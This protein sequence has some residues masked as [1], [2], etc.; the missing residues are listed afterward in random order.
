MVPASGALTEATTSVQVDFTLPVKEESLTATSFEVKALRAGTTL[1]VPGTRK[2]E[3]AVRGSSVVFN[4]EAPFQDGDVVSVGVSGLVSM[5]LKPQAVPFHGTFTVVGAQALQP[6]IDSLKPASG[7][8]DRTTVVELT[9]AGFRAGDVVRVGGRPVTVTVVDEN[10]LSLTIPP[11]PLDSSGLPVAGAAAVEVVDPS[12][13]SALKLGGFVFRDT[14]KLLALSPDRAPQQGGVK[15]QLSGRGFAPGMKVSFGGTNSF[16]VR[17]LGTQ[18]AE[19]VAPTHVAGVVDVGVTLEGDTSLLPA[20]FLYGSGAVSRLSTPPVRDVLVDNGVAYA[21]LG[22]T[23][24]VYGANGTL[25]AANRKTPNGGLLLA[26]LSEPTHVTPIAQL[27]FPGEGGSRRVLKQGNTVY[28]AAGSSGVQRVNVATPG[29]PALYSALTVPG[30]AVDIA[31]GGSLLFVGDSEGVKVFDVSN[32][33][34][35]AQPLRV[36]ARAIPGGVGALALH[37]SRLLVSSAAKV[38]PKFY[39]LDARTGDLVE[40]GVAE[41]VAPAVHISAEGTRAFLALGS[42][43]QVAIYELSGAQPSPAGTLV[44][45]DPLGGTW[46]SAEQ[47]RVAA[48]VAYVAAGGGKVQRFSVREGTAP[49]RLGQ[50]AVVGDARTLAFMGRYLLVGT[51]VLDDAGTAVELPLTDPAQ[52][53]LQ[54]AGALASVE[55]DTLEIRGTEPA[56]GDIVAPGAEVHVLLTSLP[57]VASAG[58]VTLVRA[59]DGEPVSV[60]RS[61]VTDTQGG[62]VVL[63]PAAPLALDTRYELRV[64]AGLKD[65]R[66]AM[67]G[68]EARVRFRTSLNASQERPE[69]ASVSPAYGLEAGGNEVDVLGTGFLQDCTVKV[70]GAVAA[71]SQV[72]Q[73]GK[74]VHVT[75]PPGKAGAAAVEVINP[76]GLSHVRLGAYR[77]LSLPS[78]AAVQPARAPYSSR[79]VVTLTGQGLFPG[80]QVSFGSVPARSVTFSDSGALLVEVPDDVTGRVDLTVLTPGTPPQQATL[81]GGFTFTL[82]KRAQLDG[83]GQVVARKD[84][85]LF[86]ARDGFLTA[87]DFSVPGSPTEVGTVTGVTQPVD[88]ALHG[89]SLFLAGKG[90]VVR[91][92]VSSGACAPQPLATCGPLEKDRVQLAPT[93]GVTLRAVAAGDAGAYVAVAGGNELALL[94]PVNGVYAVVARTLLDSGTVLDLDLVRGALVVLVRDGAAGARLEVR[95]TEIASLTRLRE[96]SLPGTTSGGDGALTHEGA[97]LA[98]SV[99]GQLYLFDLTEVEAPGFVASALDPSGGTSST[100]SLSGPWLMAAQGGRVSWLDTTQGLQERTFADGLGLVSD[101]AVINGVAVAASSNNSLHVFRVPYPAVDGMSPLPGERV[102]QGAAVSVALASEVPST[103]TQASSLALWDGAL[104]VEGSLLASG[105]ALVFTPVAALDPARSYVARLGLG[106]LPDVVGGTVLGPWDYPLRAG[107]PAVSLSIS[108]VTPNT[109]PTAG[110]VTVSVLGAGFDEGTQVFI[111]GIAAPLVAPFEENELQVSL[112]QAIVAGPADVRVRRAVDGVEAVAASRFLYVAPLSFASVTPRAVDLA[113]GTVSITGA[114]FHRGLEVHFDGVKAFT[115]NLTASRVDAL[116]PAGDERH[117]TLTLSQ[118]G[119]T[120]VVVAQAVYRGDVRAPVV[121]RVEPMATVGNQNVP[122]A[123]VFDVRFDET[124]ASASTQGLKLLR[125]PSG[126]AVPGTAS[127]LGDGRTLRFTPGAALTSTTSYALSVTGVTDVAGNI[128]PAF[129]RVFRTVDTVKPTLQLRRAGGAVVVEQARFAAEVAWTFQVVATDDSGGTTTTTL[130]VDG[131][132]VTAT[133]GIYRYTW[134]S[135]AM[136]PSVLTATATDASGNV[137]DPVTVTVTVVEDSPPDVSFQQPVADGTRTEGETQDILV[138]ASDNHGLVSVELHLDGVPFARLDGLSGTSATLTRTLRLDPVPGTDLQVQRVLTAYATDSEGQV[139]AAEQRVVTVTRDAQAPTVALRSPVEGGRVVGGSEL[140]L[141][142]LASDANGVASVAFFV[143]GTQV[144]EAQKAPWT[145]AWKAPAV[146]SNAS[147]TVKAVAKDVRGNA[148]EATAL[149]TVEPSSARPYVAWSSPAAGASLQEGRPF[150]VS[151]DASASAG[152]ASVRVRAG[153]EERILTQ[154]PW[155]TTFVA[156]VLEAGSAPLALEAQVTDNAGGTSTVIRRQV[157]VVDD[158]Q[159]AVG[160]SLAQEPDGTLLLGG[161]TL[162]LT[163]ATD[164]G[165]APVLTAK[166]GSVDLPVRM[167][168]GGVQGEAQLPEGPEGA[169][170]LAQASVTAAGGA[171]AS[172][173]HAGT[174]A[175]LSSGQ[176]ARVEDAADSLTPVALV[177]RGD[178]VLVVRSDD[179]G[180]GVVELRSRQTGVKLATRD[181]LG[182]PVGAAFVDDA[183]VV[184]LSRNGAGSLERFSLSTLEPQDSTTLARAPLAMDGAGSWLALGT[185]E[186]VEVRRANGSLAGRLRL[187]SVKGVSAEGDRLF[188]LTGTQLVAVDVKKPHAPKELSRTSLGTSGFTAV[189]A[190]ADGGVCSA[191]AGVKCFGMDGTNA[192]VARGEA[193]M[194]AP[195]VSAGAFGELLVVGTASGAR[196]VDVRGAPAVAGVYP[197]MTGP[198]V[199]VPGALVGGLPRGMARLPVVRG[200]ATPQLTWTLV[201]SA[202]QGSRLTLGAQTT[203]D[204]LPLNG[205][206]AEL[207]VNGVVVDARDSSLPQWV[208]LPTTGSNA[209]V[210]LLVRDLAGRQARVTREVS[211]TEPTGGPVLA[212]AE[213]PPF[214]EEGTTFAVNAVPV[215]PAQV[216]NVEVTLASGTPVLLPA[217]AFTGGLLAPAVTGETQMQ[218]SFVAIDAQGRRGPALVLPVTVRDAT[219]AAPSVALERRDGTGDSAIE[220]QFVT[221]RATTTLGSASTVVSFRLD[222]VEVAWG[223]GLIVDATVRMPLVVGA[224]QV[225]LSAVAWE[226]GRESALATLNIQVL[227]DLT[228]PTLSIETDPP[229][230]VVAAGTEL[231]ATAKASDTLALA[232]VSLELW[233][234]GV[235]QARSGTVLSFHVPEQTPPGTVL[236]LRGRAED[237]SGNVETV[238]VQRTVV[239]PAQPAD[240]ATVA[241]SGA[242]SVTRLGERVYAAHASGLWI[243]KVAGTA[244]APGLET[245]GSLATPVA[246]KALAVWGKHAALALGASGLWLV[247]VSVPA[248]PVVKAR[249]AGNYV[250]VAAADGF[251]AGRIDSIYPASERLDVGDPS[252]PVRTAIL[253]NSNLSLAGAGMD[254]PLA[255]YGTSDLIVYEAESG[256]SSVSFWP[257]VGRVARADGDRLVVGTD[258]SLVVWTRETNNVLTKVATLELPSG[259]R[260]MDVVRGVAYVAGDDG[261][262]RVVDLREPTSPRIVSRTALDASGLSIS[263]GL[264]FAAGPEGVRAMRLPVPTAGESAGAVVLADTALGLTPFRGGALVAARTAGVHAVSVAGGVAPTDLGVLRSGTD[265][266][267]VERAGRDV[268]VLDGQ[269]LNVYPE[270]ANGT[271]AG[272][273]A[274]G[275]AL[276]ASLGNVDRFAASA[277]RIWSVSAGTVKS[278][279]WPSADGFGSLLLGSAV[280]DVAGDEQHA[281]VALGAQGVAV[282]EVA[283]SGQLRRVATLPVNA[284]TVAL[285]GPLAIAGGASSFSVFTLANG[286]APQ[287]VGTVPT[288]G[289]VQR[290]RLEGRLALVS[291]G[292]AGVELWHL[293]EGQPFSLM[294]TLAATGATDAV[295]FAG[296]VLVASGASGVQAFTPPTG[297]LPAVRVS[298]PTG[299]QLVETGGQVSLT[300]VATGVGLDS[301]ELVVDGQPVVTLDEAKLNA[302]WTV[303]GGSVAGQR[304]ALQ[305]RVRAAG[306]TEA[307]SSPLMVEVKAP[308]TGAPTVAVTW[309]SANTQLRSG[310]AVWVEARRS[311]GV[312]PATLV[313]RLGTLSLGR[314]LPYATD[315]SLYGAMFRLPVVE[316]TLDTTL[317]VSLSDGAGRGAENSILVKVL[318]DVQAPSIPSGLPSSLRAGPYVNTFQVNATDDGV[319][320]L[321]LEKDGVVIAA[322]SEANVS[323]GLSYSLILPEDSVGQQVTLKATAYD[324]AGHSTPVEKTYTVAPDGVKPTVSFSFNLPPATAI[325]GSTITVQATATDPDGDL[326]SI[327]LFADDEEIASSTTY[328]VTANYT[329]PIRAQ[330]QQVVFR[331]VAK[332]RRGRP[333]EVTRTTVLQ[334]NTPPELTFT[335]NPSAP[336]EGDTVNVCIQA[337][338]NGGIQSF[339][340]TVGG[341]Q[342]VAEVS[343]GPTCVRKCMDY[344]LGAGTASIHVEASA[345]DDLGAM[346]T[347]ARDFPVTANERPKVTLATPSIA[348]KG[349]DTVLSGTVTDDRGPLDWAEF[350]VNGVRVGNRVTSVP[351]GAS[352]SQT[353]VPTTLETVTVSLVAQDRM[354]LIGEAIQGVTV[355][356]PVHPTETTDVIAANDMSFENQDIVIQGNKTLRIDGAH[357]FRNLYVLSGATLTHSQQGVSGANFLNLTVT[358]EVRVDSSSKID[359]SGR[360]Y[361]GGWQEG[362]AQ[363][364][365]RTTGNVSSGMNV[366]A[367]SHGGFGFAQVSGSVQEKMPVH[368]DARNPSD[369]GS[370]GSGST[371]PSQPGGNG[372]GLLR[373]TAGS[374]KLDGKLLA[375]G[376]NGS[377]YGGAGGGIRV[378]VGA[379]TGTGSIEAKGGNTNGYGGGGGRVAVYYDTALSSFDWSKISARGALNGG[380]GT[381]YLKGSQQPNGE[382]VM[383]SEN[384]APHATSTGR[385]PVPGGSYERFVVRNAARVDVTEPLFTPIFQVDHAEVA[386]LGSLT[387]SFTSLRVLGS[388][389]VDLRQPW[390]FGEGMTVELGDASTLKVVGGAPLRLSSLTVLGNNTKLVL[391]ESVDDVPRALE[392]N[393]SGVM[394]VGSGASVDVSERGYLG[395]WQGGNAQRVGRTTGN[396]SSGMN[397]SAGSHGGFGFAQVSGGV[398]EKMPVHDDARNPS[399]FGSG[400]SGSTS[401]SQPGGNGGGLLRLTAGSLKL[402]GKLLANGGNGSSY[403]GA[404]GGI[405]VDVGALTGTGSIEAKG[406]NTNGY[407]GGGGRVAVYYDT[408]LSSFDWSKISARG[409]L[410]GGVGTVYLKGSQ[411]PN[412]ELV[413]DSE[414]V[415]PHATST[416]RTPVPGGS[417]E[418]FVV[419]NAARVDVTEPLF[420]PIFQVA[421]ADVSLTGAAPHQLQDV[422]VSGSNASLWLNPN[423][424]GSP[425]PL[426]LDVTGTLE[427]GSGASIDVS[428][429]GYLGGWQGVNQQRPGRTQGNVSTGQLNAGGSHGG[430]GEAGSSSTVVPLYDDIHTPSDFGAGGSGGS[431][432]S[433]KGGN[434]GGALWVKASSFKLDGALKANGVNGSIYGGAGGSIRVDVAGAMTGAGTIDAVGGTAG[435]GGRVAITY[436]TASSTYDWSK[437]SA[438][439]G[440]RAGPGTVFLKGSQ[441][442]Y[443]SLSVDH[444][445]NS[446][447]RTKVKATQVPAGRYDRFEVRGRAWVEVVGTFLE[448]SVL[449]VSGSDSVVT[450][451]GAVTHRLSSLKVTGSNSYVSVQ[452]RAD[453]QPLPLKLDVDSVEVGSGA[454]IN[455]NAAG[456]LGGWQGVNTQLAARTTGNVST[457]RTDALGGSHGGY[458]SVESSTASAIPIYD[459]IQNPSDFGAGGS[460]YSSTQKGGNGGG[461]LWLKADSLMLNGSL[462]ANGVHVDAWAR[463]GAGGGIRLEVRAL[464]GAGTVE[465]AG[466]AYGGGGRVAVYYDTAATSFDLSRISAQGGMYAKS[467]TVFLKGSLQTNGELILDQL[468]V[469]A[470]RNDTRP[471]PVSGGTYERVVVRNN[472][473][474]ELADAVSTPVLQVEGTD[475]VLVLSGTQPR[476]L[477][478]LKITGLNASLETGRAADGNPLTLDL[479]VSGTVEVGTG[480]SINL[481]GA[482]YLGGWR[483]VNTQRAGRTVGNVPSS[484]VDVNASHAGY[485]AL[486]NSVTTPTYGDYQAPTLAGAGGSGGAGGSSQPGVNGGG[487]LRLTAPSLILNGKLVANSASGTNSYQ[488]GAGGSI[489]LEVGALTGAGFIEASSTVSGGGGR[490]AVYHDGASTTFDWT[491]ISATGGPYAGG[492]GTV[493]VKDHQE[494]YGDLYVDN[495][496]A[497]SFNPAT[498]PATP[499]PATPAG[500]QTFRNLTLTRKASVATPDALIITGTLTV[501]SSSRLQSSNLNLP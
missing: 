42:A 63:T 399:D 443:G 397:V 2:V 261:W 137:S 335:L 381:V 426:V 292:A 125:N 495:A 253:Q 184:A 501:D 19:A 240:A 423:A 81:A 168:A 347:D 468:N 264:L 425:Q 496:N 195:A 78:L 400:G 479:D 52:A 5:S 164:G 99:G 97:R 319:V 222:G 491:H 28:V 458:G 126:V 56:E 429:A 151:V 239:S 128:T 13:L 437:V 472:A 277:G 370:G 286:E 430:Y 33:N 143:D 113:G 441:Q 230:P 270:T 69:V 88:L 117:L 241:L 4:P 303:P 89:D 326:E 315:P 398:Q 236:E 316:S 340:A 274:N 64:G 482:G 156:P 421:S 358:Q 199:L 237:R 155:R 454:S 276:T 419:R 380:V 271:L 395:G 15:V 90:E 255:W 379:L 144:G 148:A 475:A 333:D 94:A 417:Y 488:S 283:P 96:V 294:A 311:G 323:T 499:L 250:T 392:L 11:T 332:D 280:L 202:V 295:V 103:V 343:C 106:A 304:H 259:V 378:D 284:S 461:A 221:V 36:G 47:T 162:V 146:T 305:V 365:G 163:G 44:V 409:A 474:A 486:R 91:Y 9:G 325:E 118:P 192:L 349:V 212:S 404:G 485:G 104:E 466:G 432:S 130:K 275:W 18:A 100:L 187:G 185:D 373:L 216:V 194:G 87:L 215:N 196:V 413:M 70:G 223:T 246:P 422:K 341:G 252:A 415:A 29:Q 344:S 273:S 484:L 147:R 362:N 357:T 207:S 140:T 450:L 119:A 176:A 278:V 122:L 428:G 289:A 290:V 258:R 291:E 21:A 228:K 51:L 45:E 193:T 169:Q 473:F 190:L 189:A 431:S 351:S 420:T 102:A 41:L 281:L 220:G 456:F 411:Q 267:Q 471:T 308:T 198:A 92:D 57:D 48:G 447:D 453:G 500:Q 498:A 84:H 174:L 470:N 302:R 107:G 248:S 160:V 391:N 249:I 141:E 23:V 408:A 244:E 139:S 101:V 446:L 66:G 462:L 131:Q 138:A 74:R 201:S 385:T 401:P 449:E 186:G 183:V 7:R 71:V 324:V 434:G 61:V 3:Y 180:A 197:A 427:V 224:R 310:A 43:K 54:L 424:N 217:P 232:R 382:L 366:S 55:L 25:L 35:A 406:G 209:T 76:G 375:N 438:K 82:A 12:G 318:P 166:V 260:A 39:V 361:L 120:P 407:G 65:L 452:G 30:G 465:A 266:R 37:G 159:T 247:D 297:A 384:V 390:A 38:A 412:G 345:T 435:G 436:D 171:S 150:E 489:W 178:Q 497:A 402:D 6:R 371:S 229:G 439:G 451:Q 123:A 490:V 53:G 158:G 111:G 1:V 416:G 467:G 418:R 121:E 263:G 355:A 226:A 114:G 165:V 86:V 457:G 10:T 314:L 67:L 478:S 492:P 306:G 296:R 346:T 167:R 73:D 372:G 442:Q 105:H 459:D 210:E 298:A 483:E 476:A 350:R 173:E 299:T 312:T 129:T 282:V 72:S 132:P 363:R 433:S 444:K 338:D 80:S 287:L 293:P 40:Q 124:L 181:V 17:V 206:T 60:S 251:Y 321:E 16:D 157:T 352:L 376:G 257:A 182:T 62:Q 20:S 200:P 208:D 34:A 142:A 233:A 387:G 242:T 225:V 109:G 127:L 354:G 487:V 179:S 360:G 112:P 116:V 134:P 480:A 279:R 154:A 191:G 403:G 285:A 389:T 337:T 262:L 364:V 377:S 245:L 288:V 219:S 8:A 211:L 235:R 238:T 22:A 301:A 386:F 269:V 477:S 135:S 388:S 149:I 463:G 177:S 265:V 83:L 481:A 317:T 98:A 329:L 243:G 214:V 405:R 161:S 213:V 448:G 227:D 374:L 153:T 218:V 359:V 396:V 440:D 14:L 394:T 339:T 75:V 24:D 49:V 136:G 272:T 493:Y 27:T 322:T 145:V 133:N 32:A 367:G 353:W 175:V 231:K 393:V 268:L 383:D 327:Q 300:A 93:S 368:D 331:A 110:G 445:L 68:T 204:A 77:Y 334:A 348:S 203:D 79:Q 115:Q 95:S 330:K 320:W 309:P 494:P 307:L 369:F 85:R 205:F 460:A 469:G 59:N 356:E 455:M 256:N 172:V 342:M 313:A 31:L 46:V 50:A 414:N 410:N 464:T 336:R 152:V 328:I 254:G 58:Q 234:G 188:A 170:V 26:S 108:S